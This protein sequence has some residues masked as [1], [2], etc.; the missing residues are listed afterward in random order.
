MLPDCVLEFVPLLRY[1]PDSLLELGQLLPSVILHLDVILEVLHC[2][3]ELRL[4]LGDLLAQVAVQPLALLVLPALVVESL[5]YPV[6]EL[7][8][9][10]RQLLHHLP[11][12]DVVFGEASLGLSLPHYLVV[13]P[14]HQDVAHVPSLHVEELR[15]RGCLWCRLLG[16]LAE[17]GS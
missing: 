6:E 1:P 17:R 2:R 15:L 3:C 8:V 5:E 14:A 7:S 16:L 12:V 4:E 11:S 13:Y 9:T 10:F